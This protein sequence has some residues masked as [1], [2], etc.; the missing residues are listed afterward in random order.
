M[1]RRP[2]SSIE[3]TQREPGNFVFPTFSHFT[4]YV[5]DVPPP[6]TTAFF[7]SSEKRKAAMVLSLIPSTARLRSMRHL[8]RADS[9]S[10]LSTLT[11]VFPALTVNSNI[12]WGG[13]LTRR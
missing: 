2:D 8:T 11:V 7:G 10:G 1:I 9:W 6:D 12:A 4:L 3:K 5:L 13:G